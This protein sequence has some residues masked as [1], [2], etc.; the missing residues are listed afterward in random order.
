MRSGAPSFGAD[1]ADFVAREVVEAL[2]GVGVYE[3]PPVAGTR[4]VRAFTDPSGGS[5]DSF[6]LA[7]GAPRGRGGGRWTAC[8]SGRPP[9]RP[10]AVVEEFARLLKAYGL[11][12]G[13]G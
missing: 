10:E 4:Y 2:G 11:R 1:L 8:A 3:R 13:R 9:F 7:V 5:S 12:Q 6:T